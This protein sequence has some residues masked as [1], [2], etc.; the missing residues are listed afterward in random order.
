MLV[1]SPFAKVYGEFKKVS[2]LHPLRTKVNYYSNIQNK[3]YRCNVILVK[4]KYRYVKKQ[5]GG[6]NQCISITCL[7]LDPISETFS[8]PPFLHAKA[9]LIGPYFF[10][11]IFSII[12]GK[13]Y[14]NRSGECP[15]KISVRAWFPSISSYL[16]LHSTSDIVDVIY[17]Y[18]TCCLRNGYIHTC[19]LIVALWTLTLRSPE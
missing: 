11:E 14:Q 18:L 19:D 7:L 12:N 16:S 10:E 8:K 17:S 2:S 5:D 15:R 9:M 6:G 1:C 4:P 3:S 13:I